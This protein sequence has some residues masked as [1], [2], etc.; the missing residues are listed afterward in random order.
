MNITLYT[1]TRVGTI[2]SFNSPVVPRVGEHIFLADAAGVKMV[3]TE[4][5][6]QAER[7]DQSS[8][9]VGLEVAPAND[10]A[11]SYLGQR[12]YGITPA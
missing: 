6:Y 5:C 1:S 11:R 2:G 8:V 10:A 12:L 4:V 7:P 9:C 3:V